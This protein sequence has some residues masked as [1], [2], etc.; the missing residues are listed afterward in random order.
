MRRV[1]VRKSPWGMWIAG[2][3]DHIAWS[4]HETWADAM[5]AV[6]GYLAIA[7]V[8]QRASDALI[9]AFDHAFPTEATP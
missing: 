2:I 1:A 5:A 9:A 6:P 7:E 8:E 3:E 4:P